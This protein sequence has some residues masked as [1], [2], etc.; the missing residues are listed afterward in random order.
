MKYIVFILAIILLIG[1]GEKDPGMK[2]F[3]KSIIKNPDEAASIIKESPYY[4][5]NSYDVSDLDAECLTNYFGSYGGGY[6]SLRHFEGLG[7]DDGLL[8]RGYYVLG[9]IGGI[10]TE[11]QFRF[12]DNSWKLIAIMLDDTF[13]F[14]VCPPPDDSLMIEI[15]RHVDSLKQL[16]IDSLKTPNTDTN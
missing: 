8:Y 9:G 13:I 12:E 4:D 16:E 5:E 14:K 7:A 6:W 10:G 3:I 11:F 15:M 2:Q 1:C